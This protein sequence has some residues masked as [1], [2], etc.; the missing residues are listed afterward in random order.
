MPMN[1]LIVYTSRYGSTKD[2]VKNLAASIHGMVDMVDLGCEKAP[3]LGQ[4]QVI[5]IGGPVLAGRV[6]RKVRSFVKSHATELA[7][8]KVGFFVSALARY[9]RA[10]EYLAGSFPAQLRSQAFATETFGGILNLDKVN[11]LH[12]IMLKRFAGIKWSRNHINP[13]GIER[14]AAAVNKLLLG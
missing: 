9:D 1:T 13:A 4:Y 14:M 6:S 11:P 7:S 10:M 8:R 12:R 2:S 5:I 3:E